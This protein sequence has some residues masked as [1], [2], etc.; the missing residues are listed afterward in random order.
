M[1]HTKRKQRRKNIT[2]KTNSR[3]TIGIITVPLTPQKKYYTVC[4][5]SYI[6]SSHIK[7]MKKKNINVV[8]IP[9][10]TKNLKYYFDR[11][12]GLYLPSGGAFAGT[13]REY[14]NVCKKML[15]YAMI[16]NDKGYHF[17]VWGCCMGFQQMLIIADGKDD[18]HK[19]LQTFDSYD[20]YMTT[21]KIDQEGLNSKIIKGIDKMTLKKITKQKSTLN[22]HK[23]GL[24]KQKFLRN[25]NISNF[26][27]IVGT[28]QDRKKREFVAI[29]EAKHYPFYGV[30]WH[31]ERNNEMD[32]FILYFIRDVKKNK[33]R[34]KL[35]K[36]PKL[37]TKRINCFNYSEG[38][39]KKCNFYWHKNTSKQNKK[40]CSYAQLK[41]IDPD[42]G[43]I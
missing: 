26:Y 36:R 31:P 19:L 3:Y 41:N 1:K 37:F 23:L 16:E 40:L 24:S 6:A 2:K 27:N 34:I 14:Y 25:K 43:G 21:I 22:N 32:A 5:N 38:L 13:Q 11:I 39:Y 12:H 4:G 9:H 28:S 8:I 10:D 29:I 42:V 33:K 35:I 7:W 15:Q 20:N 18:I 30:Q 17:P